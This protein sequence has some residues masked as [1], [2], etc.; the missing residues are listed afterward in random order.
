MT[1]SK[2]NN[3]HRITDDFLIFN[4]LYLHESAICVYDLLLD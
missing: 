1:A 3:V 4:Y 2:A